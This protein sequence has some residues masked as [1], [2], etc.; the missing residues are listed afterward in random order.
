MLSDSGETLLEATPGCWVWD[1][2][3]LT[4]NERVPRDRGLPDTPSHAL[5]A[6]G[7][8]GRLC[9]WG[10]ENL[11]ESSLWRSLQAVPITELGSLAVIAMATGLP[12]SGLLG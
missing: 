12:E 10:R 4:S 2:S 8:P 9:G 6:S 3:G 5:A 7:G 1:F 11:L